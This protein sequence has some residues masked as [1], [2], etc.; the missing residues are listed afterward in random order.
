MIRPQT[1][2]M[3]FWLTTLVLVG[4]F[5]GLEVYTIRSQNALLNEQLAKEKAASDEQ[6][7]MLY[8]D[9]PHTE[10]A[11]IVP[12]KNATETPEIL[13]VNTVLFDYVQ[14]IDSC[15]VHFEGDCVN[16]RSGPGTDYPVQRQLRNDIIL[17]VGGKV[18]RDGKVW[19]KIVF[20]ETLRYP[21]RV[22][23]DWYVIAD[24]VRV[25]QNAGVKTVSEHG[26]ASTT[27]QIIIDIKKQALTAEED[28]VV[29]MS[30][31]ISTGLKMTPTPS[32][33]FT[34]FKKTPSRYMQG[35]LPDLPDDQYYDLPGVPWNL[36][37]TDEGAVIHGTYWHNK[38]GF[39]Y[40]HGCVN[41]SVDSAEKLYNWAELGTKVIVVN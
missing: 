28:G 31:P 7:M 15:G 26:K 35:P 11:A 37:F 20:D 27:K 22:N 8:S 23:G 21:E 9:Y 36:Y 32:G 12:S 2:V 38:F 16:A 6:G 14:I 10:E 41:L 25:L 3:A 29:F 34:I 40:S 4:I 17:K 5:T 13:P 18:E 1:K 24:Y 33:T 19:Y 39:Q 30:T